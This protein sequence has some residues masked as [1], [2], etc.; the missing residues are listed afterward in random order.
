[1][2]DHSLR[3]VVEDLSRQLE[4][5]RREHAAT[6]AWCRGLEEEQARLGDAVGCD[7]TGLM[8]MLAAGM[9][10]AFRRTG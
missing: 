8:R 9:P 2:C 1:M 10:S 4:R 7:Q 5:L 6:R 3:E